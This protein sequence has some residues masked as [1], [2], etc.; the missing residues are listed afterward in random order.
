MQSGT[1]DVAQH[2]VLQRN[3]HW[4]PKLPDNQNCIVIATVQHNP[5]TGVRS[6]HVPCKQQTSCFSQRTILR[7]PC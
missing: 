4:W 7:P 2:L 6:H 5:Y 1:T 3:K